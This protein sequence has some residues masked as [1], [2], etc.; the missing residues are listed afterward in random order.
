MKMDN[1]TRVFLG[2]VLGIFISAPVSMISQS[3][4]LFKPDPIPG[5]I[6]IALMFGLL[7]M[8]L[9]ILLWVAA[10]EGEDE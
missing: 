9:I 3:G 10:G 7:S 4:L 8:A 1:L 2:I 6:D 5:I